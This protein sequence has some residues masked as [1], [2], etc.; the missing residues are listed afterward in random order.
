MGF[1]R[2]LGLALCATIFS[3]SIFLF[4]TFV[5]LYYVFDSPKPLESALRQ[6]GIYDSVVKNAV[7][8]QSQKQDQNTASGSIPLNDS[9]V[10]AAIQSALP[11]A[12]IQT[13]TEKAI[14][15]IYD[16]VHGKTKTPDFKIDLT[17]EQD[18]IVQ[19]IGSYVR[20]K[21]NALP[22]CVSGTQLPQNTEEIF[23]LTCRPANVS[24]NT[25]VAQVEKQAQDQ[26]FLKDASVTASNL[27][28]KNGQ[29]LLDKFNNVPKYHHYFIVS[30][31]VLPLVIVLSALGVVFAS[32]TRRGGLRRISVTLI[33]TGIYSLA[34]ALFAIWALN[35]FAG[36]LTGQNT[37][38]AQVIAGKAVDVIK[39]L[40]T[41]LRKWWLGFGAGYLLL[42]IIGLLVVHFTKPTPAKLAAQIK[43]TETNALDHNLDI[44]EAG[45]TFAPKPNMPAS[46]E[47]ETGSHEADENKKTQQ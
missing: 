28:D 4:A 10:S 18:S 37:A 44:P 14:D 13:N 26:G 25:L 29:P 34:I 39:I 8:Q 27:K 35:H 12:T 3:F 36:N 38:D 24:V 23:N 45:T 41:D 20:N 32:Q 5:G 15:S 43:A 6:S 46:A 31:F 11:P 9:G 33:T 40:A 22:V 19:G 2:R 47:P 7:Q 17:S 42:G 1:L 21:L 30:L 16:W